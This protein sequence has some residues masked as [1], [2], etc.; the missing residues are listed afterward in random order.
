MAEG[1]TPNAR[2]GALARARSSA[3][4]RISVARES[5]PH[6]REVNPDVVTAREGALAR[7]RARSSAAR[8]SSESG[9]SE[10]PPTSETPTPTSETADAEVNFDDRNVEAAL[11]RLNCRLGCPAA[12]SPLAAIAAPPT[13]A[14]ST[15]GRRSKWW[16]GRT[17][18][19][20][21]RRTSCCA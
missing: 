4:A 2:E 21:R 19:G 17:T 5:D 14:T 20:W 6:M 18:R 15:A 10:G 16:R 11:K 8:Y 7:A 3:S 9:E 1:G 12:V 13:A